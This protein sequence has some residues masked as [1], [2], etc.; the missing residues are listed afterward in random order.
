MLFDFI[1]AFLQVTPEFLF[2][3]LR[4]VFCI[5]LP[6]LYQ[7]L[8]IDFPGIGMLIDQGIQMR[9][10]EFRIVSFIMSVTA[11]AN[12]GDEDIRI[13][14]LPIAG[15]DFSAFHNSLCIISVDMQYR[16][17]DGSGQGGTIIGAAGIVKIGGEADLVVDDE[18]HGTAGIIAFQVAH[19]QYFIY[20]ALTRYG[21]I[22]VDQYREDLVIIPFINDIGLAPC[23]T[24][25]TLP[26]P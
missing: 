13:E 15:S 23:K 7:E 2:H 5:R 17:M 6:V 1:Q 14:F 22:P 25:T 4:Q 24:Y 12:H 18:V 3:F 8:R 10:G 21:G 11:V 16:C 9:L 19:L 20:N 26:Y